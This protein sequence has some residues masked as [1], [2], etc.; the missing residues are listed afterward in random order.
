M[1]E[2]FNTTDTAPT[3]KKVQI[4]TSI[5]RQIEKIR[6]GIV[7]KSMIITSKTSTADRCRIQ[8]INE[9]LKN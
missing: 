1:L 7:Q 5:T 2:L 8:M 6:A 4:S 9:L 3:A